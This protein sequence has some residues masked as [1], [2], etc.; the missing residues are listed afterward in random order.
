MDR[1]GEVFFRS[2]TVRSE[3]FR[4]IRNFHHGFS[5][6]AAS[7]ANWKATNPIFHLIEILGERNQLDPVQEKMVLPL[8]Q[9]EL[10]DIQKDPFELV[11]LSADPAYSQELERMRKQLEAWQEEVKDYGMMEDSPELKKYFFDYGIESAAL[12]SPEANRLR[13]DVLNQLNKSN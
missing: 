7:T 1:M 6:N 11:N 8:P 4:Y 2:R 3:R 12:N 5:V 10:Y 13:Q 9:E